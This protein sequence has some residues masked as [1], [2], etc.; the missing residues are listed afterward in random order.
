MNTLDNYCQKY[1][2]EHIDFLKLDV[3]GHE[4]AVFKDAASMLKNVNIDRIQ[5]EYG[6]C[7]ID[8]RVLLKDL[9]ELLIG[10]GYHLFKIFPK[11]LELEK[12]YD[13]KIENFQYANWLAVKGE[14]G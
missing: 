6:G 2:V 13:Q 1:G 4:F 14:P 7:N 5:F 10:Y 11:R 9:F 12:C 8:S 3:E